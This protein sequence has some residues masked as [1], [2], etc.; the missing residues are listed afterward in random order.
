MEQRACV[1]VL[2]LGKNLEMKLQL[3]LKWT[4]GPFPGQQTDR[5]CGSVGR[6]SLFLQSSS[7]LAAG[8]LF[9]N[10]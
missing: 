1:H 8:S 2:L 9:R 10:L 5:C 7:L 6:Q 4:L 3:C